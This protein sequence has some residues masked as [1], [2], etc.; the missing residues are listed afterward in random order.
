M[1]QGI[2]QARHRQKLLL[3]E[4]TTKEAIVESLI[5]DADW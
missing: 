1:H 4:V 3:E 5:E 2:E